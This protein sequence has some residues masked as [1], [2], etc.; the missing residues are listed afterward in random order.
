MLQAEIMDLKARL[1]ATAS[2]MEPAPAL[3]Q[4]DAEGWSS[5][6]EAEEV[7]IL[8]IGGSSRHS[9]DK[10]GTSSPS[11][12][13]RSSLTRPVGSAAGSTFARIFFK[14]LKLDPSTDRD[15]GS[16][17]ACPSRSTAGL[18]PR[19]IARLLLSR[20]IARLHTWWPFLSLP[21]L[22]RSLDLVYADPRR[23][24]DADKFVVFA[25]LALAAAEC[26]DDDEYRAL[27]DLNEAEAYFNT[28]L[29]FFA[30]FHDHPRDLFGIQAVLLLTLWM[31]GSRLSGMCNDLWHLSRYLMSAGI[32]A[33]L[34]RH[35][36]DWGFSA[37][38]LEIR[39]RTWWCIYTLER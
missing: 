24:S 1:Q 11:I 16:L 15:G 12:Q 36:A 2:H 13:T 21:S 35:N 17:D 19:P 28:A 14:Q 25:V 8:A 22:R 7:G 30:S 4:R 18:P 39:N 26:Q 3:P 23:C 20:Y 5:A 38:E 6:K 27:L 9:Q 32:E 29:R 37:D 34:H 33:G 10:Y 31:M